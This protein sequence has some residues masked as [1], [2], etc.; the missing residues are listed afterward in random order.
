M[1][2][3]LRREEVNPD[4]AGS[5]NRTPLSHAGG[6]GH[7]PCVKILLGRGDIPNKADM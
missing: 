7:E 3:L 2:I 6:E 1:K 5:A 4:K